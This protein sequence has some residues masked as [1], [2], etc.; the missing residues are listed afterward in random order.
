MLKATPPEVRSQL[1]LLSQNMQCLKN[2][3]P[4]LEILSQSEPFDAFCLTEHWCHENEIN[5]INIPNFT[6]ASNFS[7]T[8]KTRG[9]SAIFIRNNIPFKPITIKSKES[10]FEASAIQLPSHKV[11]ILC[12]YRP[13]DSELEPFTELLEEALHTL[14]NSKVIVCGDLNIDSLIDSPAKRRLFDSFCLYDIKSLVNCPTRVTAHSATAIDYVATNIPSHLL[15]QLNVKDLG[16]SDHRSL[17]FSMQ[18]PAKSNQNSNFK[19]WTRHFSDNSLDDFK[20]ALSDSPLTSNP[21]SFSD[22]FKNFCS[23]YDSHFPLKRSPLKAAQENWIT[24]GI[25]K[26]SEHLKL[27]HILRRDANHPVIDSHYRDFKRIYKKVI[28][29][30]KTLANDNF[31]LKSKNTAKAIWQVVNKEIGKSDDPNSKVTQVLNDNGQPFANSLAQAE[32]LNSYFTSLASSLAEKIPIGPN[33]KPPST[34]HTFSLTPTNETEVTE[35]IQN[36]KSKA[37]PDLNGISVKILKFCA[38]DLVEKLTEMINYSFETGIFPDELKIAKVI[39]IYK[40]KGNKTSATNYRPIS[41]LPIFSKIYETIV[42]SRLTA[43]LIENQLLNTSQH[44]F[45]PGRNTETAILEFTDKIL[46]ALDDGETVT[47]LFLDLAKAFDTVDHAILLQKLASK[48]VTNQ[49]LK[50]FQ[51]YLYNRKQAVAVTSLDQSSSTLT[52]TISSLQ[53][54]Y[55]GVPQG[56]VLG[57][58]LFL[59]YVDD[60]HLSLPP[61]GVDNVAFA[62]DH[63]TVVHLDETDEIAQ[64]AQLA[65]D[66]ILAYFQQNKLSVNPTKTTAMNFSLRRQR[67]E[68]QLSLDLQ[69]INFEPFSKFLGVTLDQHLNWHKHSQDLRSKLHSICFTQRIIGNSCS[70]HIV[71]MTYH[72]YFHSHLSYG[73]IFWG[74]LK[75]NLDS[76]FTVQKKCLRIMAKIPPSQ[77]C[78]PL[79]K[80]Y[81]I[82]PAPCV[83]IFRMLMHIKTNQILFHSVSERHDHNTR[84]GNN[85]E[86]AT[87]STAAR[88]RSPFILGVKI[89]NALPAAIRDEILQSKFKSSLKNLLHANC[90]YSLD[91]YFAHGNQRD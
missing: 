22:F 34:S 64:L 72:A 16:I 17:I 10:V 19:I 41:I 20:Q 80:K 77:S 71:L 45:L 61:S 31:I 37:T 62:D 38:T 81:N 73:I 52:T 78:R 88:A 65:L 89:Y 40:N 1:S 83:F 11:S 23:L 76:I 84:H 75:Q 49:A 29:K 51:S 90:F 24:P 44:G 27:L 15:P 13:P 39:P 26:S 53:T 12:I 42:K 86:I 2:K 6:L 66:N 7:R 48:G 8:V 67:H 32:Y 60:L 28:T 50:W 36:L 25:L 69:Q 14:Q 55:S 79:F 70:P 68:F 9:G 63:N 46:K 5:Q 4:N 87:H 30:A 58:L 54:V 43:Y 74:S 3:I 57:P 18:I 21:G 33:P 91:E 56:S 82:L 85:L 47:A 59:V 35:A